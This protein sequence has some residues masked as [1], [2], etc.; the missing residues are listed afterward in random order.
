MKSGAAY[1]WYQ[2][3]WSALDWLFPPYCG[4]CERR[5]ERWCSQCAHETKIIQNPVC[6]CCGRPFSS[7]GLCERCQAEPP[8]YTGLRSYAEFSGPIRKALHR[9]KYKRDLAMGEVLSRPMITYLEALNWPVDLVVPVPL[10]VARMRQRGY[11]QATLLA[12]PLA[13]GMGVSFSTQAL[14]RTRETRSQVDLNAAERKENVRGAFLA[15]SKMVKNQKVL[16]VD[17]VTTTGSTLNECASALMAAGA[18]QVFAFTLA[19]A[20]SRQDF[21]NSVKS[22]KPYSNT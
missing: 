21:H 4:G 1:W 3:L 15:R 22:T 12:R 19:R 18:S 17:D 11:N 6:A 14:S 20:V 13:L 8:S 2:R 9:L 5:G 16:L 10:G 7:A